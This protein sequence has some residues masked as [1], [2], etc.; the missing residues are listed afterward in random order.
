MSRISPQAVID[1]KA[2]IADDVE[3]GPFCLVGPH[4]TLGAGCRLLSHV[5][6]IG[7]TTVGKNN[8]FYPHCAIGG[9]PQDK[10]YRGGPTR[11]EIGDGNIFREAS[12]VHT[13]TEIAGGVTRIGNNNLVMINCHIAHDAQFG[14]NCILANNVM[15][16]GHVVCGN[17]VNVAG[18]AAVQHFVRIGD[19]S[20]IC[21][22]SRIR[23]DVPPFVKVDG[24][25]HIRGHNEEGL[26]RGGFSE[27]DI[28][29]IDNACRRLFCDK[30]KPFAVVMK[31]FDTQNGLNP[32]VKKMIEF[33]RLRDKGKH[34]RYLESLRAG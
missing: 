34:G 23:K 20:F 22:I 10:K 7:H 32:Q 19:F 11:L 2:V 16:A 9:D 1:P 18:G 33:L 31:E 21:G 27:E 3:V 29:A 4:V 25:D 6:L 14:N 26:R 12:T 13:G 8:I 24:A 15:F 30:E 28:A 5:V 17:N